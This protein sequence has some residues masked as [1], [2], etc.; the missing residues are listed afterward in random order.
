[1]RNIRC[2][3][4]L[5]LLLSFA[6]PVSAVIVQIQLPVTESSQTFSYK[7]NYQV[8]LL[9]TDTSNT[10][11]ELLLTLKTNVNDTS[12]NRNVVVTLDNNFTYVFLEKNYYYQI[13]GVD[14][15]FRRHN[16]IQY[17][18]YNN[19]T[20]FNQT[21]DESNMFASD[22]FISIKYDISIKNTTFMFGTKTGFIS[23]GSKKYE[24]K[25]Y[26]G[27]PSSDIIIQ[28]TLPFDLSGEYINY[29]QKMELQS[30]IKQLRGFSKILYRALTLNGTFGESEFIY[31]IVSIIQLFL[32]FIIFLFA[33]FFVYPYLVLV[34]A[35]T[36]G[37]FFVAYKSNTIREIVFNYNN[38]VMFLGKT[39]YSSVNFVMTNYI[40]VIVIIVVVAVL[41]FLN[42]VL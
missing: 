2:I 8:E 28:S 35:I 40:V 10:I 37:N 39:A 7:N 19:L 11:I 16:L 26:M 6:Y 9:T 33:L 31:K 13:L 24:D 1:M 32:D 25:I 22:L 41:S 21:L 23:I 20:V 38:F 29:Y 3:L 34:Y 30:D 17:L 14:T 4:I 5:I 12:Q 36:F 15:P 42:W 18:N 27:F